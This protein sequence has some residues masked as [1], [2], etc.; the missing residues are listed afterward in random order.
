MCGGPRVRQ[1]CRGEGTWTTAFTGASQ[2]DKVRSFILGDVQHDVTRITVAHDSA[3][4][5]TGVG[6][7]AD[8]RPS[9]QTVALLDQSFVVGDRRLDSTIHV[10][11]TGGS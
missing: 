2:Y 9:Q 7:G 1:H 4:R 6:G 5:T 11:P 10:G 8:P 3:R